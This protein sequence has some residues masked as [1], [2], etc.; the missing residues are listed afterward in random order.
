MVR[1]R[2]LRDKTY[3]RAMFDFG[4]ASLPGVADEA[5]RAKRPDD[6]MKLLELNLEFFPKS[7]MTYGAMAIG[8]VQRGD[9]AAARAT[10]QKGLAVSPDNPQLLRVQSMLN[11]ERP[12]P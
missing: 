6:A 5:A 8:Q 3:G 1:Y 12:R 11:G 7:G 2:E 10:L 9:T 4:E